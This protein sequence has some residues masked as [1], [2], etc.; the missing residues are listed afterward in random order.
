MIVLLMRV[1]LFLI[2]MVVLLMWMQLLTVPVR[3]PPVLM[4]QNLIRM[5]P[6]LISVQLFLMRRQ[7]PPVRD[8]IEWMPVYIVL[9]RRGESSVTGREKL[10]TRD[11]SALLINKKP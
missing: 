2:G 10:P 4:A 3:L 1:C 11:A 6:P 8:V 9:P 5:I 7:L